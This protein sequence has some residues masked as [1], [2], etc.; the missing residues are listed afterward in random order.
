MDLRDNGIFIDVLASADGKRKAKMR[1]QRESVPA[2]GS[3]RQA[4]SEL[5]QTY[6]VEPNVDAATLPSFDVVIDN[7]TFALELTV[8][9]VGLLGMRSGRGA[10]TAAK[11]EQLAVTDCGDAAVASPA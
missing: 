7:V 8:N 9:G 10:L 2:K 1:F 6:M 4:V 3:L 11:F 5:W